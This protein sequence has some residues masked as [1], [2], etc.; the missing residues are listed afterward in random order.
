MALINYQPQ[1]LDSL[2][3]AYQMLLQAELAKA[4][5]MGN[6]FTPLT[7]AIRGNRQ[8]KLQGRAL[9]VREKETQSENAWKQRYGDQQD[10]EIGLREQEL[11]MQ[12][13]RNQ[14]MALSMEN[15]LRGPQPSQSGGGGGILS[16][17][18][19]TPEQLS[20]LRPDDI[21][22][23]E[24][25]ISGHESAAAKEREAAQKREQ[26]QRQLTDTQAMIDS[27]ISGGALDK[28]TG[29]AMRIRMTSPEEAVTIGKEVSGAV[30]KHV[31]TVRGKT[32]LKGRIESLRKA[33]K[34][35]ENPD[36]MKMAELDA[37][38]AA[39]ENTKSSPD[40]DLKH[41]AEMQTRMFGKAE[42]AAE[43]K[44][45]DL[46]GI[47]MNVNLST[48]LPKG[49]T[50][51]LGEDGKPI[52]PKDIDAELTGLAKQSLKSDPGFA[53]SLGRLAEVAGADKDLVGAFDKLESKL[54]EREK[55]RLLDQFKWQAEP[56]AEKP[57]DAEQPK[58]AAVPGKAPPP[59]FSQEFPNETKALVEMWATDPEA[60]IRELVRL[61]KGGD[62]PTII[63]KVPAAPAGDGGA[64]MR[65]RARRGY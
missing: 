49:G 19:V 60:V 39:S 20:S 63:D 24:R 7:E 34:K 46:P 59:V 6:F 3:P 15:L 14:T 29:A 41:L 10:R 1:Q 23:L 54:V 52:L 53:N 30:Q 37:F 58:P 9:D 22:D 40:E 8:E 33:L 25:T 57:K 48:A 17:Y 2:N 50:Y 55:L 65:V 44:G 27:A 36:P 5:A 51:K 12:R 26:G 42:K 45:V 56:Q 4:Q 31:D 21:M 38:Q 16:R 62:A 35:S 13:G 43:P 47:G 11:G 64:A 61:R 32:E 18:G 28:A